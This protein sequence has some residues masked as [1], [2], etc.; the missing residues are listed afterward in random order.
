MILKNGGTISVLWEFLG[1]NSYG[2][3]KWAMLT[4]DFD[5]RGRI[6]SEVVQKKE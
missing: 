2:A 4:I 6:V 3:K 1:Q 5:L